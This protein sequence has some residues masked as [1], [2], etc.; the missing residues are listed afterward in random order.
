MLY[1]SCYIILQLNDIETGAYSWLRSGYLHLPKQM[2]HPGRVITTKVRVWGRYESTFSK[3]VSGV[4]T[5]SIEQYEDYFIGVNKQW[6]SHLYD[7][8]DIKGL[9]E[10][11]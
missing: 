3:P 7:K 8:R 9:S 5:F 10:L 6:D 11:R 2:N 4:A 1:Y